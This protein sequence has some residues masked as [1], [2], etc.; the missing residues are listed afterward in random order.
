[1]QASSP[2]R[3]SLQR[4]FLRPGPGGWVSPQTLPPGLG[5]ENQPARRLNATPPPWLPLPPQPADESPSL[6]STAQQ[7]CGQL[8][9][10]C[11]VSAW[12]LPTVGSASWLEH[13]DSA[14]AGL[15]H[16]SG[17]ECSP[18]R[19]PARSSSSCYGVHGLHICSGNLKLALVDAVSQAQEHSSNLRTT[20]A[21]MAPLLALFARQGL[22]EAWLVATGQLPIQLCCQ[23]L[24]G[25]LVG[26]VHHAVV[27]PLKRGFA[28]RRPYDHL[29]VKSAGVDVRG[30]FWDCLSFNSQPPPRGTPI[31]MLWPPSRASWTRCSW[32]RSA[33]RC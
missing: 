28:Y 1:M 2:P 10:S 15:R 8:A 9:G 26:V 3:T 11:C 13:G 27:A 30:D 7:S 4:R 5:P 12:S 31:G 23:T 29:Y 6:Q 18:R 14:M 25:R 22:G 21:T 33:P 24:D 32:R 17:V 16:P 19:R 20:D